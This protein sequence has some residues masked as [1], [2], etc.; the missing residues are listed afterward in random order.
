MQFTTVLWGLDVNYKTPARNRILYQITQ[1]PNLDNA[2]TYKCGIC[3]GTIYDESDVVLYRHRNTIRSLNITHWN[4]SRDH[5]DADFIQSRDNHWLDTDLYGSFTQQDD[6]LRQQ[7]ADADVNEHP[8]VNPR[9]PRQR[10]QGR[11]RSP[12]VEADGQPL[13]EDFPADYY[14]WFD[15][16]VIQAQGGNFFRERLLPNQRGFRVSLPD[17]ADIPAELRQQDVEIAEAHQRLRNEEQFAPNR[18]FDE[19]RRLQLFLARDVQ[20]LASLRAFLQSIWLR[21]L[22]A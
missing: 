7:V 20:R 15:D 6:I 19:Q 5:L 12:S 14:R 13:E 21:T 18:D 22:I 16:N 8:A 17:L 4:C 3:N 1:F 11:Q 2:A 10:R 9:R